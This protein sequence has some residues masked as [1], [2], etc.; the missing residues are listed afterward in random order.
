V[1]SF[2]TASHR[3]TPEQNQPFVLLQPSFDAGLSRCGSEL[4]VDRRAIA[5]P[6]PRTRCRPR[7]R[8]ALGISSD[9][10]PVAMPTLRANEES[11]IAPHTLVTA[12][13]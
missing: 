5:G 4:R 7:R 12:S 9:D 6:P 13:T 11:V 3:R 2:E 8:R 1:A 10:S